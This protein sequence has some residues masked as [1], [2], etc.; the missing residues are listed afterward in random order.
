MDLIP[1]ETANA[2]YP[3]IFISNFFNDLILSSQLA[4]A[5]RNIIFMGKFFIFM[6]FIDRIA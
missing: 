4:H 5:K 2:L 6:Y 1:L 3:L